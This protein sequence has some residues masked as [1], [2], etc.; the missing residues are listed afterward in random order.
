MVIFW[1]LYNGFVKQKNAF[2]TIVIVIISSFAWP[3]WLRVDSNYL[4]SGFSHPWIGENRHFI[5]ILYIKYFYLHSVK[6]NARRKIQTFQREFLAPF[7]IEL[8]EDRPLGPNNHLDY[9][10]HGRFIP[11][12]NKNSWLKNRGI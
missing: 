9:W 6:Y 12:K 5:S 2:L 7:I 10:Y 1:R 3:L 11:V 8:L 4:K